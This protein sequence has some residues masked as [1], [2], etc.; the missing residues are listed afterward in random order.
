MKIDFKKLSKRKG[1][2]KLKKAVIE[3]CIEGD[4]C[5]NV[6]GCNKKGKVKC[7]H[8]YC[9]TFKWVIDRA[10]HYSHK[11]GVDIGDILDTWEEDRRY[12][13]MNYYQD[14]N[15]PKLT[16]NDVIVFDTMELFTNAVRV[17]PGFRC[18]ACGKVTKDPYRCEHCDWKSYGLFGC[19]GKGIHIF[20]KDKMKGETIFFPI[21]FEE[22]PNDI[23]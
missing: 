7:F 3:D 15:Q 9:N 6:S 10:K 22:N 16:G 19:L 18:P 1:Y 17:C 13:Y 14:A 21:A 20:I 12:W 2:Q 8:R 11:I 23:K 5:F 4:N